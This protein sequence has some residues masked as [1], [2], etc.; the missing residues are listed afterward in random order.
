M[1]Y[2]IV[3]F[4]KDLRTT[5]HAPLSIA[6]QEGPTLGLF[7]IEPEWL[8]S[9][10]FDS[11]HYVF[12]QESLRDLQ[13]ELRKL[14]VPLLI[15]I[16]EVVTTLQLIHQRLGLRKLFSHE[17]TGLN[18]TFQRDLRVKKWCKSL[19]I[20]W[21]E[22]RQFGVIRAL[23]NRDTW[24]N[25]RNQILIRNLYFTPGQE[26][27]HTIDLKPSSIPTL[28][29]LQLQPS[30][31][32]HAQKGGR[33]QAEKVLTSFFDSRSRHYSKSMSSPTLSASGCSRISPYLTWG[34]LSMTEVI[35]QLSK[36]RATL[37]SQPEDHWW[38]KNLDAF[39]SRLAW[40]C[41][42]IQKFESE[43]EIEFQNMNRAFDGIRETEFNEEFF[44][45]WCKG[46]TG[47]PMI[48]ASMRSLKINGWI[49]F[50]MRAALMSFASYQLWLH[51]R[52][53]AQY[54]A[55]HFIDFE[56]GIHFSQA[57]MQSGVT[58]INTIR[59]YSPKKQAI[60]QDP[61]GDFIRKFCP[62]LASL[63][64]EDLA[65]PHLTPPLIAAS[66]GF[67]SG[68]S[69]PEPI[70]DPESSYQNAKKRIFEWMEKPIVRSAANAVYQKH[71]SRSRKTMK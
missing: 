55:K 3:W 49:N 37:G 21:L 35:T 46:E 66:L 69:Y 27:P 23:R 14:G 65:E 58:G 17:E 24:M 68:V 2:N 11:C 26:W 40:H 43:P 20:P 61:K 54:L 62:E 16:G 59:I 6:I 48:D 70:V 5:D 12:L 67:M 53:P 25:Q 7:I 22:Y 64:T 28:K 42:F 9:P 57:Q 18:W 60:E 32:I 39:E 45:A 63:S 47:F 36:K 19:N 10:E 34:N 51:W 13:S 41:H 29:D 8:I 50:R 52:K 4:K 38:L 56:P 15:E 30:E 1:A 33:V 44:E 31:K 71:G